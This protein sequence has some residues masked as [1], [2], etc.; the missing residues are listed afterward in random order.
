MMP[1]SLLELTPAIK[2]MQT[3][4]GC[5]RTSPA[6]RLEAFFGAVLRKK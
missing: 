6:E 3:S 1:I 2:S 5:L 4:D